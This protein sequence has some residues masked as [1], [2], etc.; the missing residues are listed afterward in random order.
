M[1]SRFKIALAVCFGLNGQMALSGQ[2]FYIAPDGNDRNPGTL[3]QPFATIEKA[4]DRIRQLRPEQRQDS[5]TVYVR[6]G[7][8]FLNQPIQLLPQDSGAKEA[9]IIYRAFDNEQPVISGGRILLGWKKKRV[10]DH[11]LWT[12]SLPEVKSGDWSFHQLWVNNERR[13]AARWPN[14]G[15][16]PVRRVPARSKDSQWFD[17]DAEFGVNPGEIPDGIKPGD[18]LV[19]MNRWVESRLPIQSFDTAAH[20]VHFTKKSVFQLNE[21]DLYYI[22]NSFCALDQPGE[23]HLDRRSGL[24][25]YYPKSGEKPENVTV[26]A[27]YLVC[28]LCMQGEADSARYVEHVRWQNITW[29]H[30]EWYFP[31]DFKSAWP[32]PSDGMAIG[33]FPQA[34]IGVPAAIQGTACRNVVFEKCAMTHLGG[35]GVDWMQGCKNNQLLHCELADLG[36]GGIKIG[37]QAV[38]KSV[39]RQSGDNGVYDCHIH[40]GGRVFHSAI[41]VWIG[42]SSNNQIIHNHIHDFYYTGISIGWTWGYGEAQTHGNLVELNHVHHIGVLSNGD[43]PILSDMAAIYML[44][45]QPGAIIRMNLFHDV[46]GLRYGGWGIYFD[47]GSTYILAENNLVYRTT[48]GGFHQHYG[49]ENIVRN[50]IFCYAKNFQ[51]QRSRAEEHTSF[52]FEKNIVYW[53]TGKLL[54]GRF[55]DDHFLFDR[56]LYWQVQQT[57]IQFDDL[58]WIEWRKK[59]MDQH[60]VIADPLFVDPAHDDFRL[61]PGSPALRLGFEPIAIHKILQPWNGQQTDSAKAAVKTRLLYNQDGTNIFYIH[62]STTV[63][64]IYRCVDETADVGVTTFLVS[65]NMGQVM[66]YP[67]QVAGVFKYERLP[68]KPDRVDSVQKKISDNLHR[69]L[70]R[71]QDPVEL[72]LRRAR[73]RGM[74]AFITFRM[75]EIHDVDRP[76]SALLGD[77]WKKHVNWRVGGYEGWGASAL[78][79]NVA[80]VREYYLALLT[81]VCERYPLDGLELDFMRFPYYF[82]NEE[83]QREEHSRIMTEFV[84]QVAE[85]VKQ[86]ASRRG[87]RILLSARVPSTQKSCAFVGL[88]PA[89]WCK[90]DYVDFITVSPFLSTECD[91]PVYEF[92]AACGDKPV[93]SAMEYTLG[94][95]N[96]TPETMAAAA[97]SLYDYGAD[98]MYSFNFFCNREEKMEAD[99]TVFRKIG[100]PDSLAGKNKLY[101]MGP[102]KYPIPNVSMNS[103]LPL[104]L[105]PG[106]ARAIALRTPEEHKA[107]RVTLWLEAQQ[108]LDA[109]RI[110]VEFNDQNLEQVEHAQVSFP[111]QE[112]VNKPFASSARVLCFTVP[113]DWLQ[114]N[115]QIVLVA[116]TQVTIEYVYLSVEY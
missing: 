46:A 11:D 103:V 19:V 65:P 61:Q 42:Q 35:Y 23:W 78:D 113:P 1:K 27:P 77:F 59:G 40:D 67:S 28:L 37:E 95:R 64:D 98:G 52:S 106:Q 84:G 114:S 30:T 48:H 115:N 14:Q 100:R 22:E 110:Y 102:A 5:P 74:E 72:F 105:L 89:E 108:V 34:A 12:L 87:V 6:A 53:D 75:N 93:Y 55:Q 63:Q 70:D 45:T 76:S 10:K 47:E 15:Y 81:E 31:P 60:S 43:G 51:I 82:S 54:E 7:S 99:F 69:L 13:P 57:P 90:L 71:N 92:K 36:A 41:G 109:D 73:L 24:L 111:F 39:A 49:R 96:M 62:D 68:L 44:G 58:S 2:T 26:I 3:A 16:L 56:N 116:E 21:D 50:N 107:A 85:R 25:Y 97:A 33:G 88:N 112:Q 94:W 83:D 17:G 66:A 101:G 4:R 32:H 29:S 8:Y 86:I 18:E 38:P 9:P 80:Q 104:T 20:A 79:Y 91:M